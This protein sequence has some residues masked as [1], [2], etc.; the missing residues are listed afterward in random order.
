MP[1]NRNYTLEEWLESEPFL[2]NIGVNK[3][4]MRVRIHLF[5]KHMRGSIGNTYLSDIT[6]QMILSILLEM[7][8]AE[9][10]WKTIDSVHCALSFF[11]RIAKEQGYVESNQCKNVT[12]RKP[13]KIL[14]ELVRCR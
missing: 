2:S 5:K 7:D 11:L 8:A 13:F 10:D 1:V 3:N 14:P 12:S 6:P 9:Y 4:T